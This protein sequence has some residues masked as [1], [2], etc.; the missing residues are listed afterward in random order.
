MVSEAKGLSSA[1]QGMLVDGLGKLTL[2]S[3]EGG[4][5]N[6]VGNRTERGWFGHGR[7]SKVGRE[8]ED[9]VGG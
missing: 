2:F 9:A 6:G 4:G 3:T 1:R 5:R 7:Q 8:R